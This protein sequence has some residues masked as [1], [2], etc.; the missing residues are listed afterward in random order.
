MEKIAKLIGHESNRNS[1]ILLSK[2]VEKPLKLLSSRLPLLKLSRHHI[3]LLRCEVSQIET[4]AVHTLNLLCRLLTRP[5]IPDVDLGCSWPRRC[6]KH[7]SPWTKQELLAR[8]LLVPAIRTSYQ[9]IFYVAYISCNS[10]PELMK[11][12]NH[13][14]LKRTSIAT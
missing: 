4:F 10:M 14:Q 2:I 5:L 11:K 9:S 1:K 8:T 7:L 12:N 3:R 6:E 13:D